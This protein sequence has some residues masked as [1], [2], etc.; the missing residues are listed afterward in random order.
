MEIHFGGPFAQQL[1]LGFRALRD[2]NQSNSSLILNYSILVN[3][4]TLSLNSVR[5]SCVGA[6]KPL[7]CFMDADRVIM[8]GKDR[9]ERAKLRA[10]R[11]SALEVNV[12]DIS[13]EQILGM[14]EIMV[15]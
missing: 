13:I 7:G 15:K 9:W 5:S 2:S 1:I 10:A 3:S 6:T 4:C 11:E 12:Q 8:D 14:T